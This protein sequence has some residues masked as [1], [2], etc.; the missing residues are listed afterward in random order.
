MNARKQLLFKWRLYTGWN[1]LNRH[2]RVNRITFQSGGYAVLEFNGRYNLDQLG[3]LYSRLD[4]VR[5][6]EPNLYAHLARAENSVSIYATPARMVGAMY[7]SG[8]A[9]Q[10]RSSAART[11]SS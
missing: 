9:E 5:W 6:A 4:G 2:F 7:S 11:T 3:E 10:M 1:C 8:H